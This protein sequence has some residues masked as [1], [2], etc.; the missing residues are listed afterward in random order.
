LGHREERASDHLLELPAAC[1]ISSKLP[2]REREPSGSSC[3]LPLHQ[4]RVGYNR[5]LLPLVYFF[6]KVT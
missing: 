3:P 4:M 2:R 5:G 1:R 6:E